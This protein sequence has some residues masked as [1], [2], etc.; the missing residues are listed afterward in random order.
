VHAVPAANRREFV[1]TKPGAIKPALS[2]VSAAVEQRKGP[3]ARVKFSVG[4]GDPKLGSYGT[5]SLVI[6]F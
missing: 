5:V 4:T 3:A 2:K 1:K 6:E